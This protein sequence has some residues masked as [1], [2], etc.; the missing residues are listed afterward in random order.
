MFKM[1]NQQSPTVQHMELCSM[2]LAAWKGR[3]FGG[4][5]LKCVYDSPCAVHL[6]LTTLLIG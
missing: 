3:E 2:S 1:D 4:E 5:K 6:K